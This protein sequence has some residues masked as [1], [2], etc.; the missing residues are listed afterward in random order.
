MHPLAGHHRRLARKG[1]VAEAER[2]AARENRTDTYL[3]M[4]EEAQPLVEVEE[5]HFVATAAAAE[6]TL[7]LL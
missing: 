7:P 3:R 2:E 4:H 1:A 5:D 6:L